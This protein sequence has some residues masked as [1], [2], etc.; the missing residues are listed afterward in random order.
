MTQAQRVVVLSNDVPHESLDGALPSR[1]SQLELYETATAIATALTQHGWHVDV[2]TVTD[3]VANLGALLA[4][5]Q[6][7]LV[8][9]IVESLAGDDLRGIEAA[10]ML[11]QLGIPFTGTSAQNFLQTNAKEFTRTMLLAHGVRIP[12]GQV[13]YDI[14]DLDTLDLPFPLIVKP[15]HR[16]ASVGISQQSVVSNRAALQHQVEYIQQQVAGPVIVEQFIDGS[17]FT[18]S[19]VTQPATATAYIKT[20]DFSQLAPDYHRIVSYDCKWAESAYE[21]TAI[22]VVPLDTRFPAAHIS[23]INELAHAAIAALGITSYTNIDI[24]MD[25]DGVPYVI[26]VNPNCDLHPDA[27]MAKVTGYAGMSYDTLIHTIALD[28]LE[29]AQ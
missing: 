5:Y 17:E 22:T 13:V 7:D 27:G 19:F 9:N 10:H 28:A 23:A 15:A 2:V 6:P 25:H 3:S 21:Y 29:R 16:H 26:D 12:A 11:A 18:A 1:E 20:L 14:H 24:R 4:P 8:F